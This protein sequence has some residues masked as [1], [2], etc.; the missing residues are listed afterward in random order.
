M[1]KQDLKNR[2]E[3]AF[4]NFINAIQQHTDVNKKR[5]DG[6][7]SV[8]EIASHILKSTSTDLGNT[9]KT[10]RPFDKNAEDIKNL[11]LD[12]NTKFK[13]APNL[14]PDHRQYSKEEIIRSLQANCNNI[15]KMIDHDDLTETCIDWSVPGWGNLTKYECVILFET[16]TIRHTWQVNQ[17]N[18]VTA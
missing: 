14:E 16:H 17:F 11:F 5:A 13:N 9:R 15:L 4:N 1:N 3:I 12:F 10:E 8:G 2:I 7:W 18:S 6:G